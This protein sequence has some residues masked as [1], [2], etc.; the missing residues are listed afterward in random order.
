MPID[1]AW[2]D[3]D[4]TILV[5]TFSEHWTTAEYQ[6]MIDAENEELN[7]IDHKVHVVVDTTASVISPS[8]IANAAIYGATHISDKIDLTV[9][10]IRLPLLKQVI[11]NTLKLFPKMTD[12]VLFAS[13]FDDA[14][15]QLHNARE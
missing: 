14:L 1:Y 3:I 2:Y 10:I 13:T 15:D 4:K 12:R 7:T 9:F 11:L 6:A 8:D 5:E